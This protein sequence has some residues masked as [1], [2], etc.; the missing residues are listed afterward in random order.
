MTTTPR[1]LKVLLISH[2]CASRLEGQPKAEAL[3]RY[4]DIDLRVLVPDRWYH[5]GQWRPAEPPPAGASFACDVER[6]RLAW[7]GPGQW[8]LHHYPRLKHILKS[9]RLDVIDLW[10]EPWGLVSAHAC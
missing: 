5:Y 10:E 8:Y 6:I 1:P 9:F 3:G 7:T 2:T 4:P